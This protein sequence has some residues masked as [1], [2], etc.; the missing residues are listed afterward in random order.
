MTYLKG[1]YFTVKEQD[2]SNPA[3]HW[4]A[5]SLLPFQPV[6]GSADLLPV[7]TTAKQFITII[8]NTKAKHNLYIT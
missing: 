3:Q 2:Y 8:N 6:I 4:L 1:T 7:S 5:P